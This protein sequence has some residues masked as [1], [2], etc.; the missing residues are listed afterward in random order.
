MLIRL[1]TGDFASLFSA[2]RLNLPLGYVNGEG[3]VFA[4]GIWLAV[5]SPSAGRRCSPGRAPARR[6]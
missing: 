3:C 6:S 2:G 1:V 5:A 4:M